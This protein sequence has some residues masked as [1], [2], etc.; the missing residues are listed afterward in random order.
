ME[1]ELD[2]GTALSQ[3]VREMIGVDDRLDPMLL[4]VL[5]LGRM[6][7]RVGDG[8]RMTFR[9]VGGDEVG[10]DEASGSGD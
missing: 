7:E 2:L 5:R 8:D 1:H 10:A 9:R 4:D 6:A 3:K